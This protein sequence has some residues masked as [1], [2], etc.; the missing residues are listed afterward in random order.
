MT[1]ESGTDPIHFM[2]GNVAGAVLLIGPALEFEIG[3]STRPSGKWGKFASF[4]AGNGGHFIED[5]LSA[6]RNIH[7]VYLAY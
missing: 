7:A 2:C 3:G 6:E 1:G 5:L 4:H